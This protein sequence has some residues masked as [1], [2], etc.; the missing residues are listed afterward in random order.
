MHTN[1]HCKCLAAL[2]LCV[3]SCGG[4]GSAE[5]GDETQT[6]GIDTATNVTADGTGTSGDESGTTPTATLDDTGTA[7]QDTSADATGTDGTSTTTATTSDESNT[8]PESGSEDEA[9]TSGGKVVPCDVAEATLEPVPPNVMLV[10]GKSGSMILNTWDHD[11]NAGTA[12]VTRWYSLYEVVDFVVTTFDDQINFGAN[13]FPS[14]GATSTYN[15]NACIVANGP[16]IPAAPMNQNAILNGIPAA[17]DTDLFGGTPATE[18]ITVARDHL[19]TLNAVNPRAIVFIT[20][21]AANCSSDAADNFERFEVYDDQLPIVV[22]DAWNDDGIPTYVVGIDIANAVSPIANDGNPDSTNTYD[23]LNTVA[24]AGG[25]PLAG[26]EQ[27][28]QTTNQTELQDA[29]QQI[30]DQAL[31][32]TVPLDPA[33][34]FPDLLEVYI[35]D[36]FVPHVMDCASEDGWVY[37]NPMGP[38]DAIELCNAWCDALKA[39][40]SVTAEYYCDPG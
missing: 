40:G 35:E 38:Y 21:G 7:T 15:A 26:A 12:E 27:F 24:V 17:A 36:M 23:E 37:T 22:G 34:A 30:I 6:S 20:D 25:Q 14:E 18:G 3:A 33:P 11:E 2:A 16:E 4:S 29:M 10:L 8:A 13:L 28:Y 39:S 9:S 32:C 19:V 1:F 5:T 31:S